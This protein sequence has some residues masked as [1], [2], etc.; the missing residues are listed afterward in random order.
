ML[1]MAARRP[2][3]AARQPAERLHGRGLGEPVPHA[4]RE[5]EHPERR[6]PERPGRPGTDSG[7]HRGSG[8]AGGRVSAGYDWIGWLATAVFTTSYLTRRQEV[9]RR[10]QGLAAVVWATYG[11]LIHALPILVAH[12][13]LATLPA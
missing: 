6:R 5:T 3:H 11:A 10:V 12:I 1:A 8:F 4:D 7:G 2:R 13:I 9:L